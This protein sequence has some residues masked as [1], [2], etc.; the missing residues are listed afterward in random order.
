M[1]KLAARDIKLFKNE[2]KFQPGGD[3]AN[4]PSLPKSKI[5]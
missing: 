2:K 3:L 1:N 4:K 5:K